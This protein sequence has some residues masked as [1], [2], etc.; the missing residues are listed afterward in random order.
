M[1]AMVAAH[2]SSPIPNV[3]KQVPDVTKRQCVPKA[4]LAEEAHVAERKLDVFFG[5]QGPSLS[6]TTYLQP[7]RSSG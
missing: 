7:H 4:R 3:C 2:G 5:L 1:D 6:N